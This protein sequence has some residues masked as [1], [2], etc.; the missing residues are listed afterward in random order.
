MLEA[1]E[2]RR[3]VVLRSHLWSSEFEGLPV[4][5][6]RNSLDLGAA[7]ES[8]LVRPVPPWRELAERFGPRQALEGIEAAA[9]AK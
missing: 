2:R 6:Y 4:V 7:I 1:W 9:T 3:P 5:R 8:A